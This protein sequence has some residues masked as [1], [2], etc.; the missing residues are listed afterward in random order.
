MVPCLA[1]QENQGSRVQPPS[2]LQTRF[3]L[4]SHVCLLAIGKIWQRYLVK[5]GVSLS[6]INRGRTAAAIGRKVSEV[7]RVRRPQ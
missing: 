3:K 5:S 6:S 4:L 2:R 1:R 7:F